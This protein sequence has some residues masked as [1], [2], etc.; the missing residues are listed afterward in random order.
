MVVKSVDGTA[1]LEKALDVLDAVGQAPQGLS[2][3]ELAQ[4]LALPRTTLYRLLGSLTQRGLLRRDPL[5]RVY[6]LGARCFEYA[7]AAYA[8]PDLV[9]AA[10]A[11][12]RALRDMSGET[13]Y[14]ATLDG[15]EA[16]SLERCDGAHGVRSQSTL[17]Q[18]KPLHCTSQ[19]K[20]M[21]SA[22]PAEQ[23]DAIVKDLPLT[24]V[25]PRSITDRR[26]LQAELRLTATRGW[27]IDDEEIVP[28]VRCCG[29]PIVD[30]D[31]RVRGAISI[32]GPA[33]RLTMERL[34]LLGPEVAEA[35][36]RVGAQFSTPAD[37]TQ[38]GDVQVVPGDW[39]FN[40][41][42]PHWSA[43]AGGLFWA[44]TLGPAVHFARAGADDAVIAHVDAPILALLPY[45]DG[46]VVQTAASEGWQSVSA[47]GAARTVADL[48]R[49]RMSA[50]CVSPDGRL[51]SCMPDGDRW[52]V[53]EMSPEGRSVGGWRLAE[54]ATALA[55]D[56]RGGTLHIAAAHS[57]TLYAVQ[58]GSTGL[59]RLTT[60]PKGSGLLGGL[61][62]DRAGGIWSALRGGWSV[63]RFEP[64][65]AMDRMVALPVPC[66]TDVG[67][68]G[69]DGDTLYITSARD[70]I[71]REAL[72][73][74]PLS[75]RLF[76][77]ALQIRR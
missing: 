38:P 62:V 35:A 40:G 30:A 66:P 26:R 45:R 60:V 39:A 22:L 28:G 47:Q 3:I 75:G 37:R 31:G 68:G 51:W 16:V 71:G 69:A 42:A 55:W 10:G 53:G 19:G 52:R 14:L 74:A 46:A 2:Q 27:A 49:R 48:P 44:D 7:R 21:L 20:A 34:E 72:D 54:P 59:R 24:A 8:M 41:A 17:G 33:F 65:G 15:L 56:A 36:R 32:A 61:A 43:A 5:R 12:L 25:T 9:A 73:A 57:G 18:R 50:T 67:F 58:P 1:A 76:S 70:A 23:R 6:C 29:A 11:E 63:V 13:T 4:R 64:D 77:L